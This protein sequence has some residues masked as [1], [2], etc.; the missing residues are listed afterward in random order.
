MLKE[1]NDDDEVLDENEAF[2][3]AVEGKRF[4]IKKAIFAE[5][6]SDSDSESD[7]E[8]ESDD[9]NDVESHTS[10]GRDK[11]LVKPRDKWLVD[12]FL[13]SIEETF[14]EEDVSQKANEILDN[15]QLLESILKMVRKK[16]VELILLE[17]KLREQFSWSDVHTKVSNS[18]DFYEAEEQLSSDD[19]SD[20]ESADIP[21][22]KKQKWQK[23]LK[24]RT[25]TIKKVIIA[26][27]PSPVNEH[28]EDSEEELE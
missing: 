13:Q 16:Y 15:P 27:W 5:P 4:M 22:M 7:S 9:E 25:F 21:L 14:P 18:Y 11:W 23:A 17:D 3:M 10:K 8:I 6:L 19:D 24:D 2:E 28:N 20:V 1:Q 12:I 26:N